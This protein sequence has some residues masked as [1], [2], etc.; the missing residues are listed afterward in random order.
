MVPNMIIPTVEK[1]AYLPLGLI[2]LGLAL[3]IYLSLPGS[4]ISWD[5]HVTHTERNLN[6]SGDNDNKLPEEVSFFFYEGC[7]VH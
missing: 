4:D 7:G 1:H 2:L 3:F 5:V 6:C